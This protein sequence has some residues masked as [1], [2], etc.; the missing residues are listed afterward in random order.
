MGLINCLLRWEKRNENIFSFDHFKPSNIHRMWIMNND[1][2]E[3][4][5]CIESGDFLTTV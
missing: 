2:A 5:Y 1:N 3:A 4:P